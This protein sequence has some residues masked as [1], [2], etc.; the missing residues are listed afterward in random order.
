MIP[1]FLQDKKT[2]LITGAV[3]GGVILIAGRGGN[4]GV[5]GFNSNDL[6]F[7]KLQAGQN[8]K[9]TSAAKEI[10]LAN[11][12]KQSLEFVTKNNNSSA[13][14]LKKLEGSNAINLTRVEGNIELEAIKRKNVGA[15][16]LANIEAKS[17]LQLAKQKN[18]GA[19][20]LANI[21]AKTEQQRI[22]TLASIN[23]ARLNNERRAADHAFLLGNTTV[24]L[25]HNE[26]L[27]SISA[28]EDAA[29]I[30]G[31]T[32]FFGDLFGFF[33][34]LAGGGSTLSGLF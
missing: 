21:D 32:G 13:I 9:Q 34:K 15:A 31:I 16:W 18:I 12:K 11:L 29:L 3:I 30:G 26:I 23:Y 24:K 19:A 28:Q 33:G 27:R 6:A 4:P 1:E 10:Q 7:L 8:E 25:R 22:R 5:Y 14:A 20:W 17:D 2:L